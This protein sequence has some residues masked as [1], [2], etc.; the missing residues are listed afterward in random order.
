MDLKYRVKNFQSTF[1]RKMSRGRCYLSRQVWGKAAN[2]LHML[3]LGGSVS[4]LQVSLS[5]LLSEPA[6][7]HKESFIQTSFGLW[8]NS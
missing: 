7:Q 8:A 1:V 6:L 4:S 2:P 5:R 3:V